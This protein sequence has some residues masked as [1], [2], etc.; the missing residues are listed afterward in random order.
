MATQKLQAENIE[1][2][3]AEEVWGLKESTQK[4]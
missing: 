1:K 2:E 4:I 3:E